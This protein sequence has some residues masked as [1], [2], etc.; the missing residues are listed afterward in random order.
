MNES[1]SFLLKTLGIGLLVGLSIGYLFKKISKIVLFV[2]AVIVILV[3]VFGHN[4]IITTNWLSVKDQAIEVMNRHSD[5]ISGRATVL[6]T[7]LPFSFGLIVGGWMGLK[8][9]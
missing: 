5:N 8:K 1:L 2:A 9:G 3:F 7:N 4:E 6:L